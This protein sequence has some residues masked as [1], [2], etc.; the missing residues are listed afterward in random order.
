MVSKFSCKCNLYRYNQGVPQLFTVRTAG[1]GGLQQVTRL[2]S[3]GVESAFTWHPGV[4][5]V[6][7]IH[8][9]SVC[10]VE[11]P[12]HETPRESQR[13]TPRESQRLMPRESS[14]AGKAEK[15]R[16]EQ[17]RRRH[18]YDG[19]VRLTRRR[20]GE[21]APRPEACVF[22]PC[23]R[24]VAY[25][26]RVQ[27]APPPPPPTSKRAAFFRRVR[28]PRWSRK[29]PAESASDGV[30][31]QKV[32]VEGEWHNQV[33]VVT[34]KWGG[35]LGGQDR[36]GS[37]RGLPALNSLKR[38][39]SGLKDLLGGRAEKTARWLRF[40]TDDEHGRPTLSRRAVCALAAVGSLC[41]LTPPDP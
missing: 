26:R 8:D 40:L 16:L 24:Y 39:G 3:P 15:E 22:S 28:V 23:G 20:V 31:D 10:V 14:V 2:P 5:M 7:F 19:V 6:A 30:G 4:D 35:G 27:V 41:T 17:Q 32:K 33:C 37:M 25:V 34:L 21:A 11:V 12:P 1:G 36:G 9:G 38:C 13:L 18:A 29:P